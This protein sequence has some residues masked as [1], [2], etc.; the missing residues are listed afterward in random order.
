M[1]ST[2]M[3]RAADICTIC[4]AARLGRKMSARRIKKRAKARAKWAAK[5]ATRPNIVHEN[6]MTS[7]TETTPEKQAPSG[8]LGL[9]PG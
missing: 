7:S 6:P 4:Q 8:S 2:D 3:L 5:L 1:T 9:A